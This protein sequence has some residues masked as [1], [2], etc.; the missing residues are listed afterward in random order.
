[1]EKSQIKFFPIKFI[2]SHQK[3]QELYYMQAEFRNFYNRL[4]VDCMTRY[5][6]H[7]R[8]YQMHQKIRSKIRIVKNDEHRQ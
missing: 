8:K 3:L 4:E 6:Y 5:E 7:V 2:Q 1:M